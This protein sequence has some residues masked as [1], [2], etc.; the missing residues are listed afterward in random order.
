MFS[1]SHIVVTAAD[2]SEDVNKRT[3]YLVLTDNEQK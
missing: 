1:Y 2:T 3:I